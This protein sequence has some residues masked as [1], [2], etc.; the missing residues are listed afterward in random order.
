MSKVRRNLPFVL[1]LFK[2]FGLYFEAFHIN[3]TSKLMRIL[4]FWPDM[5][6]FVNIFCIFVSISYTVYIMVLSNIDIKIYYSSAILLIF[7]T[8]SV[9]M[10]ICS[11]F[12]YRNKFRKFWILSDQVDNLIENFLAIKID[13]KSENRAHLKK[14]IYHFSWHSLFGLLLSLS[15]YALSQTLIRMDSSVPYFIFLNHLTVNKYVFFVTIISNRIRILADSYHQI[16]HVDYKILTFMRVYSLVWRLS[17][18]I[19]EI[20]GWTVIAIVTSIASNFIF[21]GHLMA[22][23]LTNEFLNTGHFVCLFPLF[24]II[25]LCFHWNR[26]KVHVKS[27]HIT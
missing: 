11:T 6:Y 10:G 2:M 9:T 8:I 23:D 17:K 25:F 19:D 4:K 15:N 20:F 3:S 22:L 13:Y 12:K 16:R 1:N 7:H 21:N 26:L 18:M 14:I 24:N 27:S 5:M